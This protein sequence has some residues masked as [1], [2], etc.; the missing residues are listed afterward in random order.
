MSDAKSVVFVVDGDVSIR[1]SL[2]LLIRGAGWHPEVCASAN[3]FLCRPRAQGP[4]CLI[5]AVSLPDLTGLELQKLVAKRIDLPM[6]FI[7]EHADAQ[8]IVQAMKAGATEFLT[9]PL[10]QEAL[11][12]AIRFALERS[13]ETLHREAQINALRECY[14]SLSPREREVMTLVASGL[15]NK[16]VG[17]KL[18]ISECTVKSHRGRMM[19]KMKAV[20]LADLVNRV[21]SLQLTPAAKLERQMDCALADHSSAAR[22]VAKGYAAVRYESESCA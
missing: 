3:D 19:R 10:R 16:Q 13:R 20:S 7:S 5:S 18:G 17:S 14:A 2:Q 4:S 22:R 6:I 11:L 1:T 8:M 21:S 9:T 15:L 12:G